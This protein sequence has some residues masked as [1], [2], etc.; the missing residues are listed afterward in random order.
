[1]PY[2]KRILYP[3]TQEIIGDINAQYN[4][5]SF[6]APVGEKIYSKPEARA[7]RKYC[8]YQILGEKMGE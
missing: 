6:L 7:Y 2:A 3:L 4:D 8:Y 5:K 1:M